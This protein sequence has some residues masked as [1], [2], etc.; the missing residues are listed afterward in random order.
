MLLYCRGARNRNRVNRD[1]IT[2]V[3]MN[4]SPNVATGLAFDNFDRFVETLSGRNTLHDTV[5]IAYQTCTVDTLVDEG[6]SNSSSK[7]NEVDIVLEF[8]HVNKPTKRRRA[9]E[10]KGDVIAPYRKKPKLETKEFLPL[11]H[12]SRKTEPTSLQEAKPWILC[13]CSI[14]TFALQGHRY[15][16]D[17]I[18]PHFKR[19]DQFKRVGI[20]HQ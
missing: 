3:G 20:C 17:G 9:Y 11:D 4:R 7:E 14:V 15:G 1:E 5:G 16:L 8:P 6:F 2:P 12:P 18:L 10:T 13:G 19:T